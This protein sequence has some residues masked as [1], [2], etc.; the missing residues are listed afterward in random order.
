MSQNI[1]TP[2]D[3]T[4]AEWAIASAVHAQL[5]DS[6]LS[7]EQRQLVR[8]VLIDVLIKSREARK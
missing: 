6:G 8:V 2:V 7:S 1:H 5:R 4:P 3:P